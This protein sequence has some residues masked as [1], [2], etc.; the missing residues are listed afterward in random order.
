LLKVVS[1]LPALPATGQ[2]LVAMVELGVE[3]KNAVTSG[4]QVPS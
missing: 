4:L 2:E 1:K 3:Y